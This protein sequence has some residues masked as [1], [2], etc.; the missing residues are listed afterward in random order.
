[1]QPI[2]ALKELQRTLQGCL[3]SLQFS[4]VNIK[5]WESKIFGVKASPRMK[6]TE[7]E[8]KMQ[9]SSTYFQDRKY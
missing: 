1:V 2:A 7:L 5:N 9:L 6:N 4:G 3:T 8:N